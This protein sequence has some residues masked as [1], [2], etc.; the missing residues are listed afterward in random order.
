MKKL[1]IAFAILFG[2]NC[3]HAQ[4][5]IA[6]KYK[7][8]ID[9]STIGVGGSNSNAGFMMNYESGYS[10]RI[11]NTR[12]RWGI[13]AGLMNPGLMDFEWELIDENTLVYSN[14]LY[15]LGYA[16]YALTSGK[17]TAWFLRGGIAPS[18]R[19]DIWKYHYEDKAAALAQL[20]IGLDVWRLFRVS[21]TGFVTTSGEIGFL[22]SYS[23]GWRFG[24]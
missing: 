10:Q 2:F 16:D 11:D 13:A 23:L 4:G 21:W 22:M 15:L 7:H 24:K 14:Y 8:E 17:Q 5:Q 20:G 12:W 18:F 3:F 19:R 9:L 6:F 1:P